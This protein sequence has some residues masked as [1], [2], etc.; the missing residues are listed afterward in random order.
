MKVFEIT[1][2]ITP[3]IK[4]SANQSYH[5]QNKGQRAKKLRELAY[6]KTLECPYKFDKFEVLVEI[7]P[8]TRR[9][10]DPPNLYPT[11]K[12]LIDGMTDSRM[13][14]DDDY[15]HLISMT[16]RHGGSL[17]GHKKNYLIKLKVSESNESD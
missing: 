8:P 11:V 14:I 9:R 15:K 6:Q 16:F 12:H 10:F 5:Y 17:S 4:I 3:Q 7:F 2:E 13:W 1:F